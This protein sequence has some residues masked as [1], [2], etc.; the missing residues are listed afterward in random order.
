MQLLIMQSPPL[1]PIISFPSDP[2]IP[3]NTLFHSN[4]IMRQT[5]FHT[6]S[7]QAL[8]L[9]FARLRN[10]ILLFRLCLTRVSVQ[11]LSCV[12]SALWAGDE[13]WLVWLRMTWCRVL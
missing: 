10:D 1:P 2:H 8:I 11:L 4:P 7:K 13:Q 6:H 9:Y 3:F 12:V 5:K